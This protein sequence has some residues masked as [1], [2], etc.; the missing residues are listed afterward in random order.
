M[1]Y[2]KASGVAGAL[3]SKMKT[4]LCAALFTSYRSGRARAFRSG[5]PLSGVRRAVSGAVSS[6]VTSHVSYNATTFLLSLR[7]K[8]YGTMFMTFGVYTTLFYIV[9]NFFLTGERRYF[10]VATGVLLTVASFALLSSEETLSAA[11]CRS[12][13]GRVAASAAGIRR[14]DM[15]TDEVRGRANHGF[16]VGLAL[17]I[18]A[19]FA[20]PYWVMAVI[21]A[22]LS[23]WIVF[24]RP[25]YGVF[26]S[27]LVLPF[28]P[29][30]LLAALT[31]ATLV[32][33]FVKV[34]RGK[35][36]FS[37]ETLDAAALGV[38]LTIALGWIASVSPS[39][40]K[41]SLL[42]ASLMTVYF[43]SAN[44]FRT[45]SRCDAV[46]S[47]LIAGGC[48]SSV[49]A[50][51]ASALSGHFSGV[52]GRL[53][54]IFSSSLLSEYLTNDPTLFLTFCV[55][56]FPA[57]LSHFIAPP[58]SSSRLPS[59]IALIAL[60]LP[61]AASR[62]VY[63]LIPIAV[64]C[65]VLLMI[66]SRRF[67]YFPVAG[68][69]IFAACL[70]LF[71]QFYDR[72]AEYVKTGLANFTASR[73]SEWLDKGYEISRSALGGIGFGEGAFEA[74]NVT[75]R[76]ASPGHVYNTYLQFRIENGVFGL[77]V[78]VIFI[79]LI[80]SASF[81]AIDLLDRA[82]T[83]PA[84]RNTGAKGKKLSAEAFAA[85]G[86]MSVGGAFCSVSALLI[87]GLADHVWRDGRIFFLFWLVA[88]VC[89][90][91]VRCVT[92]EVN[93][94]VAAWESAA[95]PSCSYETEITSD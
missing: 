9:K 37:V 55:A 33:Y 91:A 47:A 6:S 17:S 14:E 54:G 20:S 34:L 11:L 69:V 56:L 31:G 74:V 72:V 63:A 22:A 67:I 38:F 44:L 78:L 76:A 1:K 39:S 71:P 41:D 26:L 36:F 30:Y 90:A 2:G 64:S 86:R 53:S 85:A 66:C 65:S 35:R 68:G 4:S 83:S 13:F 58:R 25:E 48:A 8:F 40:V 5:G 92:R 89:S 32:S 70:A 23:L 88:G 50:F 24:S 15:R 57:A 79:W 52:P 42:F 27:A 51:G 77:I 73:T 81:T 75:S 49:C 12:K 7:L 16:L 82:K 87:Y 10:D 84:L 61:V 19:Y 43:V 60:A 80:V 59:A 62:S 29:T 3:Y 93:D 95:D 21:A 28:A 46:L 94:S 45:K 18:A